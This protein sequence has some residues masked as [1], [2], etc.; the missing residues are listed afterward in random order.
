[1][2]IFG[3]K[4][5]SFFPAESDPIFQLAGQDI[6]VNEASLHDLIGET[7]DVVL[8]VLH[9]HLFSCST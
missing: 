7:S 2:R 5:S 6:R 9:H 1:M 8:K 4:V 3:L